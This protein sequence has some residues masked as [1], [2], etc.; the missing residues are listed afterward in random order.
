MRFPTDPNAL[1][2]QLDVNS[3]MGNFV[4]A[5]SKLPPGKSFMAEG[6]TC[7]WPEFLRVWGVANNVK[8]KYVEVTIEQ[9]VQLCQDEAFGIETGDM[10]LYC[11]GP[12]YDG[13]D[14]SLVKAA[15]IR[16]V[17]LM[18]RKILPTS[19]TGLQAGISCPMTTLEQYMERE[20]W[21]HVLAL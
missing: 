1:I 17:C 12:G 3:D 7:T 6:T 8:T 18:M 19:L 11:S 13:G 9:Y 20:D 16:N 14:A 10:F 5:V 2:P 4:Y 21:S 15:D